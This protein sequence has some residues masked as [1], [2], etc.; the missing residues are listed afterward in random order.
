MLF[1]LIGIWFI[2]LLL[3]AALFIP[4][5]WL[6][7]DRL[8]YEPTLNVCLFIAP[9]TFWTQWI[10]RVTEHGAFCVFLIVNAMS[11]PRTSQNSMLAILYRDGIAFTGAT[12]MMLLATLLS[13][14]LGGPIYIAYSAY[15]IGLYLT[16]AT[17]RFLLSLKTSQSNVLSLSNFR[18]R[19]SQNFMGKDE[20][21]Q[22]IQDR[23][24]ASS[25][26]GSMNTTTTEYEMQ[27][28]PAHNQDQ[29][30]ITTRKTLIRTRPWWL[31]GKGHYAL[32]N[33]TVVSVD[34]T[35]WKGDD[36]ETIESGTVSGDNHNGRSEGVLQVS[37]LGRFDH[38]VF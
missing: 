36:E 24:R 32:T 8:F 29:P 2:T 34:R 10:P 31:P 17:S 5:I 4:N 23:R 16:M 15:T 37:R 18:S 22:R 38:W 13:M 25:F 27:R 1:V 30:E 3:V 12:F 11:T 21:A 6:H 9:E 7:L 28:I 14:R 20:I 19:R 33:E 35:D 26:H